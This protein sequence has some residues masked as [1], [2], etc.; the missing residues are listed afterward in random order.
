MAIKIT[1]F[2]GTDWVSG[3]VLNAADL[4]ETTEFARTDKNIIRLPQFDA[5]AVPPLETTL[6]G[7]GAVSVVSGGYNC[8]TGVTDGSR[9]II[10]SL[11]VGNQTNANDEIFDLNPVFS[12][13]IRPTT[14]TGD[15]IFYATF[16][17]NVKPT[18]GTES[19]GFRI[20]VV[21]GTATLQAVYDDGTTLT[22]DNITFTVVSGNLIRLSAVMV[23]GS[24][25]KFYVDG[26]LKSTGTTNLPS[27]NV[28]NKY[29]GFGV[30]NEAGDTTDRDISCGQMSLQYDIV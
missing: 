15:T 23:S 26:V 25:I 5:V 3:D 22:S 30:D 12:A 19:F 6:S 28:D 7:T 8:D 14:L 10:T 20:S 17:S 13:I 18:A 9:A 27:G 24:F 21:S 11:N 29:L 2:G 1:S 4:I 16:G